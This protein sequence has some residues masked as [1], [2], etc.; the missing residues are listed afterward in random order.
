MELPVRH[1]ARLACFSSHHFVAC[2]SC[3]GAMQRITCSACVLEIQ[4]ICLPFLSCPESSADKIHKSVFL[5]PSG[6]TVCGIVLFTPSCLLTSHLSCFP[7]CSRF[8]G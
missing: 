8:C 7:L 3:I 4:E 1:V 5:S 2:C 6:F